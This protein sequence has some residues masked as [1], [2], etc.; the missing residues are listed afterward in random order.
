MPVIKYSNDDE[1]HKAKMEYQRLYYL[2][3][4]QTDPEYRKKHCER[5][6]KQYADNIETY[7]KKHREYNHSYYE[8]NKTKC[9]IA[10]LEYKRKCKKV[11]WSEKS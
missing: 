3:R 5:N 7:R 4:R 9:I 10:S 2:K 1:R 11:D 8:K 6:K